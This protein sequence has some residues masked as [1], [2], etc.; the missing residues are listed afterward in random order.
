MKQFCNSL[1]ICKFTANDRLWS[2]GRHQ[3]CPQGGFR[4][5]RFYWHPHY[6]SLRNLN[7][8][9]HPYGCGGARSRVCEVGS[10]IPGYPPSQLGKSKISLGTHWNAFCV[11]S[12]EMVNR[13]E[14]CKTIPPFDAKLLN[15]HLETENG[16]R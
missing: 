9:T 14:K 10:S 7:H 11:S 3:S 1:G 5:P 13:R 6:P 4:T 2:L 8:R 12:N 16:E 15:F